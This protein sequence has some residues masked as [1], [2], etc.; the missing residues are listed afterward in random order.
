MVKKLDY[1]SGKADLDLSSI[2][3]IITGESIGTIV[4]TITILSTFSNNVP[5]NLVKDLSR[6]VQ[7]AA[8]RARDRL[9]S[10]LLPALDRF[11]DSATPD[12]ATT[13]ELTAHL[14]AVVGAKLLGFEE[15][16]TFLP[17]YTILADIAMLALALSSKLNGFKD[18]HT[19]LE[20]SARSAEC[21]HQVPDV[22][23]WQIWSKATG[24]LRRA[25]LFTT[26]TGF[27]G[28][29]PKSVA[30]GDVVVLLRN[31]N[32][33]FALRKDGDYYTFHGQ[34]WIHGLWGEEFL[35]KVSDSGMEEETFI[36]R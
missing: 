18:Y 11:D 4:D 26:S 21:L 31:H 34:L 7:N 36:L 17:R 13:S 35:Q 20:L 1:P 15:N 33:F 29:A 9:C 8:T 28:V 5:A 14:K 19:Y 2:H 10:K 30:V 16:D 25:S 24:M 23:F 22:F 12:R 32:P 27:M 6:F 3:L